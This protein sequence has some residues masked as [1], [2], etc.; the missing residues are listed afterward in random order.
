MRNE[1]GLWDCY[2]FEGL[3]DAP[4]RAMGPFSRNRGLTMSRTLD[5]SIAPAM[6]NGATS[7]RNFA[8]CDK[9]A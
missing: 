5:L 2:A 4:I 1:S 3:Q 7:H 8:R 9:S 6:Q